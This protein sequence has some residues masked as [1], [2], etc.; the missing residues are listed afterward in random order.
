MGNI[1]VEFSGAVRKSGLIVEDG[2]EIQNKAGKILGLEANIAAA[3][4]GDSGRK[5]ITKYDKN[6]VNLKNHAKDLT[7]YAEMLNRSAL[8]LRAAEERGKSIFSKFFG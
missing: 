7:T 6:S 5:F 3:W 4:R 2:I 8:S 1:D